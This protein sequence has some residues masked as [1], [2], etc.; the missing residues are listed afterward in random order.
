MG[1]LKQLDTP[2]SFLVMY[3]ESLKLSNIINRNLDLF[4]L[5]ISAKQP[6][7]TGL[8]SKHYMVVANSNNRSSILVAET[9]KSNHQTDQNGM[10]LHY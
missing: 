8:P 5:K 4:Q 7:Q 2:E 3:G 6:P 1:G 10:Q 9:L